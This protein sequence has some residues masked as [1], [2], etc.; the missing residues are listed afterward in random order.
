MEAFTARRVVKYVVRAAIHGQVSKVTQTAITDRTQFE[1]DDFVVEIA[2]NVVGWGVAKNLEPYTNK[3][4]DK[5]AD[6]VNEKRAAR[7]AKKTVTETE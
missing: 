5:V 2:G 6:F 4:V 1:E 7:A 3:M